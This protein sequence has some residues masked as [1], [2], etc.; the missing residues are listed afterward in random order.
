MKGK[1]IKYKGHNLILTSDSKR[2]YCAGC[3]FRETSFS[4]IDDRSIGC[5][6]GF[7]WK[8]CNKQFNINLLEIL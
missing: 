7:I 5:E 2:D 3:F 8:E 4:C 1:T 6:W